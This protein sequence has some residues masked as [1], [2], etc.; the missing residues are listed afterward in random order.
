MHPSLTSVVLDA[1]GA[2]I[3][4]REVLRIYHGKSGITWR[5]YQMA[6]SSTPAGP[7]DLTTLM[8]GLPLMTPVTVLPGAAASGN[9]PID[10]GDH[11]TLTV[12]VTNGPPSAN[13]ILTFYYDE[14]V[15]G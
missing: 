14:L 6:I 9:P 11:D 10:V 1:Q 13:V 3:A 4:P 12:N 8:N 7:M 5:I 15:A 2:A